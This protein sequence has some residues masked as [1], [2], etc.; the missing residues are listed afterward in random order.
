M[1]RGRTKNALCF[2]VRGFGRALA[3]AAYDPCHGP[4]GQVEGVIRLS[5]TP[6]NRIF[7]SM[8]EARDTAHSLREWLRFSVAGSHVRRLASHDSQRR[9]CPPTPRSWERTAP[10]SLL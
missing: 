7:A 5:A 4:L 1:R 2:Q 9:R 6:L 8:V 3:R 10:P